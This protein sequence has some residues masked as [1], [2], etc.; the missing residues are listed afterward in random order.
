M[1]KEKIVKIIK[2]LFIVYCII[3]FC[4]LFL[5]GGRT[6]N[7]FHLK[8]FSKEHFE[9]TNIIPFKTITSF[10]ERMSNNTINTD[11][12]VINLLANAL[13]FIPMGMALPVLFEGKFDKIWKITVFVTILVLIIEIIQFLTFLGSAD[14]DDLILN[15]MGTILGYGI[16]KIKPLREILKLEQE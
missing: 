1:R 9:M 3:L 10:F 12:A 2:Y 6:G 15:V 11:I 8:V 4:I 7:Q 5:Y 14:I 13:M 16:I